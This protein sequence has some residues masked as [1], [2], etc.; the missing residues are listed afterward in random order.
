L[1]QSPDSVKICSCPLR[2]GRRAARRRR[3]RRRRR[4]R[5][6]QKGCT[7]SGELL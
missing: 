7:G 5:R 3:R 6:P 2:A 4:A 1:N